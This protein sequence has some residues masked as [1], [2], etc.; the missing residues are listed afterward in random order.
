MNRNL[1]KAVFA[2]LL[3]MWMLPAQSSQQPALQKVGSGQYSY[4]LWHL[5]DAELFSPNGRFVDYQQSAP[6]Q[7]TLTY[8]RNISKTEFIDAT[9]DQWKKLQPNQVDAHK[10]W[11]AELELL[12]R[13]VKKGDRLT[14]SLQADGI[15]QFYFND[16]IL[17]ST[18]DAAMGPA[19]FDIWLS[20]ATTAKE[21]RKQLLAG[22][23]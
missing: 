4:W 1:L 13:D 19:F 8:A 15:I 7:L 3:T 11:A 14:A 2:L 10:R 6:L 12:W 23:S 5:Y 16:E 17:G 20:E 18:S 22:Q 9:M 21:L